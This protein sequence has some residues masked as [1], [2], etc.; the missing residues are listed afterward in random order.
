MARKSDNFAICW[1]VVLVIIGAS[2]LVL[3]GWLA[4]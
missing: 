4:H 3:F 1:L 2:A